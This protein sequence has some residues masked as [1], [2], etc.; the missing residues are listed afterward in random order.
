[1]ANRSFN[2]VPAYAEALK[3]D[4]LKDQEQAYL[5]RHLHKGNWL[6]KIVKRRNQTL[7]SIGEFI[8]K[9]QLPFFNA[10]K[11]SLSPVTMTEAAQELG[12]HESTIARAVANKYLASPLGVFSLKS[13]FHQ[14]IKTHDGQEISNHS[15]RKMLARVIE[16]EDKHKPLSDA[17]L[18]SHFK[19]LGYPCARRTIAKYRAALNISSASRRKRWR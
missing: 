16:N 7:R 1:M 14:G 10:E 13:F 8:L 18:A 9:R 3:N 19:K 17:K 12:L 4:Q 6:K 15:L 11:A 2:I 5:Q